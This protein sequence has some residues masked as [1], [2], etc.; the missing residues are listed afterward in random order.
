MAGPPNR[1]IREDAE[2]EEIN[3]A[4]RQD[5]RFPALHGHRAADPVGGDA[6]AVQGG[7]AGGGGRHILHIGRYDSS[8]IN[9]FITGK[10]DQVIFILSN[11][12]QAIFTVCASTFISGHLL[13]I[14]W[15]RTAT[16]HW[17]G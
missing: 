7:G 4:H 11:K 17:L 9:F 12:L 3:A 16:F 15:N 8:C 1:A 2:E 14:E 5:H 6:L 10:N 13:F